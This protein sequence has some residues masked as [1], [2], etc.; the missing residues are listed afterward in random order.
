MR[1]AI[2]VSLFTLLG[3]V[4]VAQEPAQPFGFVTTLGRD[5]IAVEQVRRTHDRIEGELVVF[6]PATQ[7]LRYTMLLTPVG[8]IHSATLEVFQ[9]AAE[10]GATPAVRVSMERH[11]TRLVRITT[12]GRQVDT[13]RLEVPPLTIPQLGN[14][15]VTYEQMARQA[16]SQGGMRVPVTLMPLLGGTGVQENAVVHHGRDT[17]A[18]DFFGSAHLL[19]VDEAGR[20]L[21][22][23]GSQSTFKVM[24]ER[25]E[26]TLDL[27]AL[28]AAGVA[29]DRA[30]RGLGALSTRDT[31]Q[32]VIGGAEL[33]VDYGRPAVRG[34]Q[35][36]GGVVP[37]GEVWRTGANNPTRFSTSRDLQV[38]ERILPAGTYTL[39]SLP[40]EAGAEIIF[41]RQPADTPG[42]DPDFDLAR[43]PA[44]VRHGPA[45]VERLTITMEP[46]EGGSGTL[47]IAWHTFV[48]R[49]PFR[50]R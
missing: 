34:R 46:G 28:A 36:L 45:P 9:G 7:V 37:F 26:G 19:H 27:G 21:G 40:T 3:S 11:E 1:R 8:T 33:S 18:I 49:V 41:S 48:W 5:T 39:L 38:G 6:T 15:M 23:D 29:R 50:V 31:A 47:V 4:A 42:H 10:R 20:L 44:E 16:A 12:R 25:V 32:A 13:L 22:M 24:A 35:I 14:S 30:G 43:I 2:L 17:V